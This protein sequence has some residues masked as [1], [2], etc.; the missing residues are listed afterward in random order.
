MHAPPVVS[1]SFS[2]VLSNI[3][4]PITPLQAAAIAAESKDAKPP[5]WAASYPFSGTLRPASY[6]PRRTVPTSIAWPD[7][8]VSSV[9]AS[10]QADKSGD[11]S[12]RVSVF[13][14]MVQGRVF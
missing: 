13:C 14:I 2:G 6:G 7:Y 1:S 5:V 10:E 12:P 8:A 3:T 4:L 11:R 9:S